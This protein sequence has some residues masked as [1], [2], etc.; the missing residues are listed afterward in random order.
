MLAPGSILTVSAAGWSRPIEISR[1]ARLWARIR[2]FSLR[3]RRPRDARR[4][5]R[6]PGASLPPHR[7]GF[8]G[9]SFALP[10]GSWFHGRRDSA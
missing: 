10:D 9:N 5:H 8:Y 6:P 4:E 1:R 7:P 3:T 2:W